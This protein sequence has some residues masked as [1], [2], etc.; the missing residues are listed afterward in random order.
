VVAGRLVVP[1]VWLDSGA[2]ETLIEGARRF[3]LLSS[4]ALIVFA[5][6][7]LVLQSVALY[8]AW[9]PAGVR[10]LLTGTIWGTGWLLHAGGALLAAMALFLRRPNPFGPTAMVAALAIAVAAP[11]AGH[12]VSVPDEA[13]L[14]VALDAIHVLAVGGW[15]GALAVLVLAVIPAAFDLLGS[16]RYDTIRRVFVAFT[17]VALASAALLVLS[18]AGGALLQLGGIEPLLTSTYGRLLLVKVGIVL[19]V[20]VLGLLNWRRFVPGVASSQGLARYR[21]SAGAE[22]VLGVLALL[23]TAVLAATTPP[24]GGMP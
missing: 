4:A 8:D 12:P 21:K 15:L 1:R 18:G 19:F 5:A 7:R 9:N 2:R 6:A 14:A 22:L 20:A 24:T 17:P 16:A 3:G 23:V 13:L 10:Q 11:L